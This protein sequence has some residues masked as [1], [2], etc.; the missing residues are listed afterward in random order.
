MA[1]YKGKWIWIT[2]ASSGI[3]KALCLAYDELNANLILSSRRKEAL[4]EVKNLCTGTG[5]KHIV[6]LDLEDYQNLNRAV[7]KVYSMTDKIDMLI[8]NGGISQRS[9]ALDTE[10]DVSKRLMD[11]NYLGTV[12]L[13]KEVLPHMIES[14]GGQ[15][16]VI[17]SVMGKFGTADRS[18]Y[19]ASK[20][21]LFG[22]FDSLRFETEKDGIDI[23]MICPGFIH[24]NVT[25]NALIGDGSTARVMDEKTRNGLEP[26]EFAAKALKVIRK[27]KKEAYI[28]KIEVLGVY[29]RRYFPA[30]FR[31]VIRKSQIR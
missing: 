18:S 31:I 29:L 6:V 20:H 11:I 5:I 13:T 17:S 16:V 4:Q 28:G 14:G 8:N 10:I 21:A 9:M 30:L 26:H 12:S 23:T 2:G 3:G 22:Y 19:A 27:K 1:D 15:V 24:T 25:L 7:E